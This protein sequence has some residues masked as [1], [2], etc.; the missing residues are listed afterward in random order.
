MGKPLFKWL[1]I[2]LSAMIIALAV[3][4][5]GSS[6][7][8][9]SSLVEVYP[10]SYRIG[11]DAGA[12]RGRLVASSIDTTIEA[13]GQLIIAITNR[14]SEIVSISKKSLQV[15]MNDTLFMNNPLVDGGGADAFYGASSSSSMSMSSSGSYA[16]VNPYT[17]MFSGGQYGERAVGRT[18]SDALSSSSS[19]MMGRLVRGSETI[20]LHPNTTATISLHDPNA[21]MMKWIPS[22]VPSEEGENGVLR[23]VPGKIYDIEVLDET[24]M[25]L[26]S[27]NVA[28]VLDNKR[29][30]LII[31]YSIVNQDPKLTFEDFVI[32][33][34]NPVFRTGW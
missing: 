4:G 29:I 27:E 31:G 5:C 16:S 6:R 19:Q 22:D 32:K 1:W 17:A 8:R 18:M 33:A 23:V 3:A 2:S 20:T 15:Y 10:K 24:T 13:D 25:R 11:V 14:S 28:R 7:V 12:N 9:I 30:R 21:L 26:H 34:R